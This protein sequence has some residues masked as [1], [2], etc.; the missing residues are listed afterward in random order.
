[1]VAVQDQRRQL[2]KWRAKFTPTVTRQ[3]NNLFIHLVI[4]SVYT[5][6]FPFNNFFFSFKSND[7]GET[8][9]QSSRS[10]NSSQTTVSLAKHGKLHSQLQMYAPLMHWLKATDHACYE[11]LLEVYTTSICKLYERDLRQFFDEAR[12]KVIGLREKKRKKKKVFHLNAPLVI[13]GYKYMFIAVRGSDSGSDMGTRHS[14]SIKNPSGT[15][16]TAASPSGTIQMPSQNL[17]GNERELW[18]VQ[19]TIKNFKCVECID[20][21]EFI[22]G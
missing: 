15:N 17:L 11:K 9:S 5:H 4:Q 10:S 1:M 6:L 3:L 8:S 20:K 16:V 7:S 21:Y 13:F 2:E 14:L 19:Y 18:T 12:S 22:T